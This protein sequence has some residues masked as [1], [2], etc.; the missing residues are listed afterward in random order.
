MLTHGFVLDEEGRKMSKSLGNV[1]SPQDII[2]QNGA[3][4]LRLWVVASNYEEDIRI[5]RRSCAIRSTP[6]AACATP[7]AT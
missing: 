1:I 3:D 5:G 2:D 6:T 4:I 7:C